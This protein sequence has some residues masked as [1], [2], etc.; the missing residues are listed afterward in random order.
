[1]PPSSQVLNGRRE[2][3]NTILRFET[4]VLVNERQIKT[5]SSTFLEGTGY[6]Y[7]QL[8]RG[9]VLAGNR[10]DGA[11]FPVPEGMRKNMKGEGENVD[12]WHRGHRGLPVRLSVPG[13]D[14]A[15]MVL[16]RFRGGRRAA[17][18]S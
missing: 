1:L 6:E 8:A 17:E 4:Y 3:L 2:N 10:G 9:D 7:G 11:L 16:T 13:P 15:G 14:P 12:V 18:R 5:L